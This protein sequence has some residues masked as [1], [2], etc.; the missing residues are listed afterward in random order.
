MEADEFLIRYFLSYLLLLRDL[1]S[2]L[3]GETSIKLFSCTFTCELTL[4]ETFL[5]G[6]NK[7]FCIIR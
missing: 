1:F 6:M 4:T 3:P 2:T 7:A 5:H